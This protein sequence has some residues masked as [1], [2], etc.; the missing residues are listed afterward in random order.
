MKRRRLKKNVRLTLEAIAV[1]A[2]T[3]VLFVL[4]RKAGVEQRGSTLY[5]GEIVVLVAVP[6]LY[7]AVKSVVR[8]IKGGL[9]SE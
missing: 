6:T 3:V 5:G 8:D 4:A 7:A 2:V 1:L 9:F